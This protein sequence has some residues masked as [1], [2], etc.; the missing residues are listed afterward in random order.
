MASRRKNIRKGGEGSAQ[1]AH[2]CPPAEED[3][4]GAGERGVEG[5]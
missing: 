5:G 3:A 2:H 4:A 1:K